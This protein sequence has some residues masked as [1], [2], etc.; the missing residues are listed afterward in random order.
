MTAISE[1]FYSSEEGG[2]T[3]TIKQALSNSTISGL[4]LGIDFLLACGFNTHIERAFIT[5]ILRIS[6]LFPQYCVLV[7][8]MVKSKKRLFCCRGR[9]AMQNA[10]LFIPEYH[11]AIQKTAFYHILPSIGAKS[12]FFPFHHVADQYSFPNFASS[13]MAK[14]EA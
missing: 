11:C 5:H 4:G 1:R 12:R 9:S 14:V 6:S 2:W 7:N 13:K 3:V 8:E 10:R